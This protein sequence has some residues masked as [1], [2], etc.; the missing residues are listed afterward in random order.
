MKISIYKI[1][2]ANDKQKF[3]LNNFFGIDKLCDFQDTAAYNIYTSVY[4]N[5]ISCKMILAKDLN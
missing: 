5:V 4:E 1:I 3:F 2:Y